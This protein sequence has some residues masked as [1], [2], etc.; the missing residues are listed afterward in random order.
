MR[1]SEALYD[2]LAATYDDHFAVPHRRAY[3]D[4]AWQ[5]CSAAIPAAPST[6]VDIGCGVGRWAQRLVSAGYRVIGVEPAP[7]MAVHAKA[8]LEGCTGFTL[9]DQRVEEVEIAAGSVDAVIAMG[10][11]AIHRRPRCGDRPSCGVA[12]AR[13]RSV[14]AG[15]LAASLGARAA[16]RR[17]HD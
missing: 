2:S 12:A 3:D 11:A 15:R 9:V 7:V 8:R 5:L 16:G 14:R 10:V 17:S 4:L 6:V 13:R 1:S